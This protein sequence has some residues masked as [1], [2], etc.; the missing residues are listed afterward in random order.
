MDVKPRK[1]MCCGLRMCA[2]EE[3]NPNVCADCA[4]WIEDESPLLAA[5]ISPEDDLLPSNS[6]SPGSSYTGF[7][8]PEFRS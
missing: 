2:T 3:N 5:K 4:R 7:A 1:C 8:E 6:A